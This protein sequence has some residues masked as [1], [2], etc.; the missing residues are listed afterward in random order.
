MI[1]VLS[2][3]Q[4]VNLVYGDE[5]TLREKL[6]Q[7]DLDAIVKIDSLGKKHFETKVYTSQNGMSGRTF[8]SILQG[9]TSN[10]NLDLLK[11]DDPPMKVYQEIIQGRQSSLIDFILPGQLGFIILSAGI[12]GTAYTWI[13]LRERNVLKRLFVTPAPK[14]IFLLGEAMSR[15]IVASLQISMVIALGHWFFGFTLIHGVWTWL[16]MLSVCMIAMTVF[17]GFGMMVSN[18]AKNEQ[19]VPPLSNLIVMPQLMLS[20]AFFPVSI[21]PE[22]L[23]PLSNALPLTH[24]NNTLRAIAFDGATWTS[25]GTCFG[26]LALWGIVVYGITI[27]IFKWE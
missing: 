25:V 3:I 5:R 18:I 1:P 20:G 22:W 17:L 27:R 6:F 19:T 9:V 16:L 4:S 11:I 2:K 23:Q 14:S 15:I 12:F 13:S 24:V 10:L 7:S 21:L 26:V 8:V